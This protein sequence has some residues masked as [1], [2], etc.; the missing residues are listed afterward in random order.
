MRTSIKVKRTIKKKIET[1]LGIK[2]TPPPRKNFSR[3]TIAA[4]RQFQHG[5]CAV[6]GCNIK[7]KL[8]A[9]HIRGGIGDNTARNCQ[10][11]C[12]YHHRQ[13]T[14]RDRIRDKIAKQ[15]EKE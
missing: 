14:D 7:T 8:E 1:S 3:K 13:K 11:L 15:L 12:P 10:L 2:K 9:D 4:I 6:N 5:Y